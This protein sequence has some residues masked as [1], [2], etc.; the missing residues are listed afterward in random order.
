VVGKRVQTSI[1]ACPLSCRFASASCLRGEFL[2]AHVGEKKREPHEDRQRY[3]ERH[4]Y[5]LRALRFAH[6]MRFEIQISRVDK[7]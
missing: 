4:Y 6:C 1:E 5:D 7:L 2:D 3:E